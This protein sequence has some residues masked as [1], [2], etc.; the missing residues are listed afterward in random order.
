MK[1]I[2]KNAPTKKPLKDLQNGDVFRAG[3][4]LYIKARNLDNDGTNSV[5]VVSIDNGLVANFN[6]EFN[7]TP[8]EGA[9]VV[10]EGDANE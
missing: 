3:D 4:W 6:A 1:V 5:M 10:K 2:E 8:V 9:F 7:V